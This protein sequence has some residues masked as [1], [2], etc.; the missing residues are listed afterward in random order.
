MLL[1]YGYLPP[2]WAIVALTV[3]GT[4]MIFAIKV[5]IEREA[6]APEQKVNSN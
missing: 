1:T 2:V 5:A 3:F 6:T 4:L